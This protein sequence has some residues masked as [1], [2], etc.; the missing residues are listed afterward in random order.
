MVSKQVLSTYALNWTLACSFLLAMYCLFK[1][2]KLKFGQLHHSRLDVPPIWSLFA[3]FTLGVV[4]AVF[5]C[6][7]QMKDGADYGLWVT[8]NTLLKLFRAN[9]SLKYAA[10]YYFLRCY[11]AEVRVLNMFMLFQNSFTLRELEIKKPK[12]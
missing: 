11:V 5:L 10:L 3:F 4:E 2:V 7:L 9:I 1:I 12:Y 6:C 8:S